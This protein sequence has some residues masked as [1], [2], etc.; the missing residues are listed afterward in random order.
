M[1]LADANDYFEEALRLDPGFAAAALLHSD[2]FGHFLLENDTTDISGRLSE[3][4]ETMA[5]DALLADFRIAVDNAPD[6]VSRIYAELNLVIFSSTWHRLPA[7]IAEL[8]AHVASGTRMPLGSVWA[9]E[10]MMLMGEFDLLESIVRER[11]QTDPLNGNLVRDLA[12]LYLVR[13]DYDAARSTLDQLRR[14]FGDW[15][16]LWDIEVRIAL[17]EKDYPT[18]VRVLQSGP[19]L[20]GDFRYFLPVLYI[21]RGEEDEARRLIAEIDI[22]VGT[23]NIA[24][25]MLGDKDRIR[26]T[27][28]RIDQMPSGPTSLAMDLVYFARLVSFDTTATPNLNR[29]LAEA[30]IDISHLLPTD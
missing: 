6:P 24:S 18:A 11:M 22:G 9:D 16:R 10:V 30:G 27:L 28:E 1:T 2:R 20:E 25:S 19:D 8:K 17:A 15:P 26:K 13:G 12:N 7:L 5:R 29:R 4:D 23:A 21:L 3:L 14:Q